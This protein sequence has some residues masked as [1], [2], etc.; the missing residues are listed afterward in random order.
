MNANENKK[1]NF[2]SSFFEQS[3]ESLLKQKKKEYLLT[4][5]PTSMKELMKTATLNCEKEGRLC[6]VYDKI[7]AQILIKD[8][9]LNVIIPEPLE[10]KILKQE[11]EKKY[12]YSLDEIIEIIRNEYS[13]EKIYE[14]P[15]ESKSYYELA[16][17]LFYKD[18]NQIITQLDENEKYIELLPNLT[19]DLIIK[20][21][22][23]ENIKFDINTIKYIALISEAQ[24]KIMFEKIN[25]DLY[26]DIKI[27]EK[28]SGY[29]YNAAELENIWIKDIRNK[30]QLRFLVEMRELELKTQEEEN[31]KRKKE[32][33]IKNV[34]QEKRIEQER[35]RIERE[36]R[37]EQERIR[38][39]EGKKREQERRR[40][41]EKR[42]EQ[43]MIKREEERR[44]QERRREEEKRIEQERIRI[45]EGKKRDQERIRIEQG[46]R[47][48]Q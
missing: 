45:E 41:E 43:E 17:E 40:E 32:Y 47:I 48:E 24:R 10:K 29:L 13:I 4:K 16:T 14:K 5:I 38:I 39:E 37:R 25:E 8:F 20:L 18:K 6:G 11:D 21:E 35:M 36:R 28:R 15:V 42:I 2:F 19:K 26:N 46:R 1:S 23:D 44:E 31:Q 27:N 9:F 34:V 12:I 7:M 30:R 33:Q 22:N 3:P